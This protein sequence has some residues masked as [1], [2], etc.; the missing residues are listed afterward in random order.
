MMSEKK[1]MRNEACTVL[2]RKKTDVNKKTKNDIA[3]TR[4]KASNGSK[5]KT[6]M[7]IL[8]NW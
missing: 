7:T 6:F 2:T 3:V 8:V 4:D 1:A 5:P